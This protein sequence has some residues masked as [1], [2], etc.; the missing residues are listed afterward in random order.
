MIIDLIFFANFVKKITV[1]KQNIVIVGFRGAG[2]SKYGRA[3]A[4]ILNLPFADLDVEVEFI[5]G[6]PIIDFVEKHGWQEFRAIEQRVVHDFSR[7]F[8]GVI[9]TGGG[10]IENSKNLQNL[11]KNGLFIFLNPS[12]M[13]VKKYLMTD[14]GQLNRPRINP[15]VPLSQEI[16]QMWEQRKGIYAAVANYDAEPNFDGDIVEEAKK[17]AA[18]LPER[19][20]PIAPPIKKVAIFSSGKGKTM[21]G[22]IDAQKKGRIPNIEFVLFVTDKA[23]S[24]ALKKAKSAKIPN[25]EVLEP[26]KGESPEDYDRVLINFV[27]ENQPD[28]ILLAGWERTMSNI[29][30]EQFGSTTYNIHQSLLPNHANLEGDD[31][32]M[33]VL[34]NEEKYTGCTVHRTTPVGEDTENVLQRK[35]L[36]NDRDNLETI[37]RSVEL[38]EILGFCEALERRK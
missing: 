10:T 35:I 37:R 20:L 36:I 17:I 13:K 9:A 16:D 28:L 32:H 31:I 3:L 5:L 11:K 24:D 23:K 26:Q 22:I 4:E 29:Y 1:K 7:N 2:K 30:C 8:S 27:R 12:F 25:I 18:I 38:Q 21:Q 34:D 6:E 14:E 33:A 19:D 15:D